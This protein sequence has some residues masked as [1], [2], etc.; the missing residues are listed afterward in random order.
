M[1]VCMSVTSLRFCAQTIGKPVMAVVPAIAAPPLSTERRE[2]G[3]LRS[4]PVFFMSILPLRLRVHADWITPPKPLRASSFTVLLAKPIGQ[5][6]P[7]SDARLPSIIRHY[8]PRRQC[9]QMKFLQR[10]LPRHSNSSLAAAP[11]PRAAPGWPPRPAPIRIHRQPRPA[12]RHSR[13]AHGRP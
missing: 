6:C 7:R 4:P 9:R 3:L 1:P 5:P 2:I 13:R 10:A 12:P 8:P 11:Y